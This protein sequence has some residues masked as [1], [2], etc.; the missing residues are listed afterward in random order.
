MTADTG[1]ILG[2]LLLVFLSGCRQ[3]QGTGPSTP[4]FHPANYAIYYG[5]LPIYRNLDR[6][7]WVIVSE[8]FPPEHTSRSRYFAYLTIGEIDKEGK[9]AKRLDRTLGHKGFQKI[10]LEGNPHWNSWVADI[11]SPAFR[12][13]LLKQVE[14]DERKGFRGI[15]LD[16]LDSPIEYEESHPS[17]GKGLQSALI[18]F[19]LELHRLHPDTPIIVNRGFPVLSRIA[20]SISG[21]LFED[22]CSMYDDDRHRYV[23]VPENPRKEGLSSI[24]SAIRANPSLVVLAL[25]YGAPRDSVLRNQCAK[26]AQRNHLV[27][28]FSNRNLDEIP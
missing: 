1:R 7:D 23:T 13:I 2:L 5:H 6:Y 16:T 11:R 18:S 3:T 27:P 9:I 26:M 14:T 19:I 21:I 15:F 22:F 20:N 24:Q 10:L 8:D 4:L 12:T 25:D 17:K 28:F